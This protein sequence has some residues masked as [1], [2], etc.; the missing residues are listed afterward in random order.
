MTEKEIVESPVREVSETDNLRLSVQ[1]E[2]E[3]RTVMREFV[4]N[5]L[6]R[7]LDFG[8]IPGTKKPTLY[9][10]GMERIFSLL[11]IR[12][13]LEKDEA[14]LSM[15]TQ[16]NVV[17]YVCRAY[18]LKTGQLLGEGRGACSVDE[19]GLVNTTVKIAEK[20][21][22]MDCCLN[23]GFSEY[24][25]QDLEGVADVIASDRFLD[26]AV[27]IVPKEEKPA[28]AEKVQTVP[29]ECGK[30]ELIAG[31]KPVRKVTTDVGTFLDYRPEAPDYEAGE[32]YWV[33]G[34][35]KTDKKGAKAFFIDK[36]LTKG[37]F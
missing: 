30:C 36:L 1:V 29:F 32:T 8:V 25:T 6:T 11:G 16:E 28:V 18:S 9:K 7:D 31:P 13:E 35:W 10:P 22:R 37:P 26:P 2:A 27:T 3:R 12:T 20:R 14:T 15:I 4:Q 21:A 34:T 24:F 5:Q 23:M 33:E 17:A 19:K